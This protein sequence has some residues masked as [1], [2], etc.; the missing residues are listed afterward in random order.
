[1]PRTFPQLMTEFFKHAAEDDG[2]NNVASAVDIAYI[3]HPPAAL[4]GGRETSSVQSASFPMHLHN[5]LFSDIVWQPADE[6]LVVLVIKS[7][8]V[9]GFDGWEGSDADPVIRS[10]WRFHEEHATDGPPDVD[11]WIRVEEQRPTCVWQNI[12]HSDNS[13]VGTMAVYYC[14][15]S[16]IHSTG[17][18]KRQDEL[19]LR[20][21]NDKT[22][23]WDLEKTLRW[24]RLNAAHDVVRSSRIFKPRLKPIAPSGGPQPTPDVPQIS[25][26][27]GP[28]FGY[29]RFVLDIVKYYYLEGYSHYYFGVIENQ[30][31]G[32]LSTCDWK[33][34]DCLAAE[35]DWRAHLDP[36][37][38]IA[39]PNME[40]IDFPLYAKYQKLLARYISNG[41]VTLSAI[42]GSANWPWNQPRD[43]DFTY[44]LT[45]IVI[46][47]SWL[48][49][50]KSFDDLVFV[51]DV[52][53]V[54]VGHAA[55]LEARRMRHRKHVPAAVR[56][57]KALPR[58]LDD[59]C[60]FYIS[61][62]VTIPAHTE[63]RRIYTPN[64]PSKLQWKEWGKDY[65]KLAKM[66]REEGGPSIFELHS[67]TFIEKTAFE[68]VK[69]LVVLKNTPFVTIHVHACSLPRAE[70][71]SE[72]SIPGGIQNPDVGD[73]LL[74]A[75]S[76]PPR[77][78]ALPYE[79]AS[80]LHFTSFWKSRPA[81]DA[82][83]MAMARSRLAEAMWQYRR[84]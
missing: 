68:Y 60:E 39:E 52:D 20:F 15:L 26:I 72:C 40:T 7:P 2:E 24:D 78:I 6:Q 53:E 47:N 83:E 71:G 4:G 55:N 21:H 33:D 27:S 79:K 30:N 32:A 70:G 76:A 13:C 5:V 37:R 41:F 28:I 45:K 44:T 84:I 29:N 43:N 61:P 34:D 14:D 19:H 82:D 63:E 11:K 59:T 67:A 81:G 16:Q 36:T 42:S 18:K 56:L 50:A 80:L 17:G 38:S 12:V 25:I 69:S 46:D 75:K 48:H 73:Q 74:G 54:I 49:L 9:H 35:K 1:M 3:E 62:K 57:G 58:T 51:A 31:S 8:F 65:L 64:V 22:S 77:C 23:L 66:P 10:L